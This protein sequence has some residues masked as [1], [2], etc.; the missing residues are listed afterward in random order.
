MKSEF[1]CP[2]EYEIREEKSRFDFGLGKSGE[3]LRVFGLYFKPTGERVGQHVY[4]S[5]WNKDGY[6]HHYTQDISIHQDHQRKNL[7]TLMYC[8]AEHDGD[9]MKKTKNLTEPGK[10]LWSQPDRPFGNSL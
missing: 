10:R 2:T 3:T 8:F 1:S 6:Y 5:K 9:K 4:F 7:A